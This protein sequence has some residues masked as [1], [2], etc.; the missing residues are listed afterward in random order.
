MAKRI[1]RDHGITVF[2]FIRE[3]AGVRCGDVN[4]SKALENTNSYKRMRCDYDP[5]YQEIYEKR[6]ITSDM[7]FLEKMK[8]FAEIEDEIDGIRAKTPAFV[9]DEIIEK[10]GV[11]PVVNCPDVDCAEEMLLAANMI[12]AT[13]DS[14]GGVVEVIAH[15][16]PAGLGEPVFYKLDAELGRMLGIG[17]ESLL[18]PAARWFPLRWSGAGR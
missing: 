10:Y 15:G 14:S 7:R 8:V 17:A 13:G 16:M 6:R 4:H 2:S 9:P 12:T 18:Y 1:L 3:L 11:H 5:F